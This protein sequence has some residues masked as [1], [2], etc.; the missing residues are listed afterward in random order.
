MLEFDTNGAPR[1][2]VRVDQSASIEDLLA[3]TGRELFVDPETVR[4]MPRGAKTEEEVHFFKP[5][6]WMTDTKLQALYESLDMNPV[7][8]YTLLHVNIAHPQFVETYRNATH[9]LHADGSWRYLSFR[10]RLE[11]PALSANANY[12]Q[13]QDFWWFGGVMKQ[14]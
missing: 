7:D 14:I 1:V 5:G 8:P 10:R 6:E 4:S 11:K 3:K 13:W 12:M 2:R 9:W